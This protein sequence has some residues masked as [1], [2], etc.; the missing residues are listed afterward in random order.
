MKVLE[1]HAGEDTVM[2]IFEKQSV[3]SHLFVGQSFISLF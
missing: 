3:K 2:D 1:E